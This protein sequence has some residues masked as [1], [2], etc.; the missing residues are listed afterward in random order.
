MF[1][2]IGIL[3]LDRNSLLWSFL[4]DIVDTWGQDTSVF[5]IP[6]RFGTHILFVYGLSSHNSEFK[7][8]SWINARIQYQIANWAAPKWPDSPDR[9][10]ISRS[11]VSWPLVPVGTSWCDSKPVFPRLNQNSYILEHPAEAI[12]IWARL[13]SRTHLCITTIHL[14]SEHFSLSKSWFWKS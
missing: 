11:D 5:D 10:E 13:R 9:P 14:K 12:G 1:E 4:F 6:E 3:R 7:K 2:N 8:S